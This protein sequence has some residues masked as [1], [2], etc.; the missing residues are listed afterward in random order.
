MPVDER[1][2]APPA[3]ARVANG[4]TSPAWYFA[5]YSGLGSRPGRLLKK[6]PHI[7]D[8]DPL[9]P[10]RFGDGVSAGVGEE[11]FNRAQQAGRKNRGSS[12]A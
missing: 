9:A 7:K 11:L 3:G 6:Y 8:R 2:S 12:N 10:M 1:G 4:F 5:F